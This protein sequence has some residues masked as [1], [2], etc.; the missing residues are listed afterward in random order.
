MARRQPR[1]PPPL[2][3]RHGLDPARMRLPAT[4]PWATLRDH[5]VERVPIPAAAVDAMLAEGRIVDRSGPLGLETPFV[6]G[7]T[8]W[9]HRDLPDE[10]AIPFPLDVVHRDERI[11]VA[12][13][14]HFLATIPRGRHVL[15]TALVRLRDELGLPELSPAH[16]LDRGTAGLVL[17]VVRPAD[18]GAYQTLFRDRRVAKSYEAIAPHRPD[19]DLPR[20]VRSRIVKERGVL[21]A[22][23]VDGE[24]NAETRVE[25]IEHRDGWARYRLEPRTGRT[26]QLRVHLAALGVPILGD[27]F[28]PEI[29]DVALD[30]LRSPLQLLARDLEFTDPRTGHAFAFTSRRTLQAWDDPTG[31]SAGPLD[32]PVP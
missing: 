8:V 23:E 20:V 7:A 16:R 21:T 6:G 3:P 32:T 17:F 24:P 11:V 12:D 27:P 19:L 9:F 18:R 5:L 10:V 22:R 4:G 29:R 2:P 25:R 13:K 28:Y 15:Q 1:R 30:D 26:H 31:W 14:P